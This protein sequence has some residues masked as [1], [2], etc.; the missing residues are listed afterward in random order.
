MTQKQIRDEVTRLFNV[1]KKGSYH[2]NLVTG[3]P[4]KQVYQII[5]TCETAKRN[6]KIA[7]KQQRELD[8]QIVVD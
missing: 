4:I 3:V 2:I 7:I 8:S 5:E 6:H 1:E